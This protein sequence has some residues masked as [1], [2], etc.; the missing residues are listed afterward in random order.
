MKNP[1][2]LRPAFLPWAMYAAAFVYSLASVEF[3]RIVGRADYAALFVTVVAVVWLEREAVLASL[4][5]EGG[6]AAA[7]GTAAFVAGLL[8]FLLGQT[9]QEAFT[10]SLWGQF[11]MPAGLV[12][13]FAP[14]RYLGSARFMALAGTAV[15]VVAM[16]ITRVLSSNLAVTI[17]SAAA[18]VLNAVSVPVVSDGVVLYFGPYS[19]EVT[20]GCSGLRSMFSLAAL[21]VVYLR[22][23]AHRGGWHVVLLVAAVVPVAVAANLG[24]VVLLVLATLS[25]GDNFAQGLFHDAAGIMAFLLALLML[26]GVDG[27]LGRVFRKNAKKNAGRHA[28]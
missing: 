14:R 1:V 4:S 27:F 20:E 23:G 12:A 17:A 21:S 22:D 26:Y 9:M 25:L 11:L 6:G 3:E 15:L 5:G 2:W 7:A 13:V 10:L 19:A 8:F 16:V 24:R 18:S 28:E